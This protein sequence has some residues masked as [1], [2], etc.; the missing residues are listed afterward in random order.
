MNWHGIVARI[1]ILIPGILLICMYFVLSTTTTRGYFMSVNYEK[2]V[3]PSELYF[4]KD[5]DQYIHLGIILKGNK[6][7]FYIYTSMFRRG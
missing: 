1:Y 4:P 3:E 6:Q 5:E 7:S 2:F